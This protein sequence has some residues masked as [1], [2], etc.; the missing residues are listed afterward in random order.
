M[1]FPAEMKAV[2]NALKGCVCRDIS[3]SQILP[4]ISELRQ[5]VGDRALLRALHFLNENERV[6]QTSGGIGRG[7]FCALLAAREGFR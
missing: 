1:G 5:K 7:E 2:V 6:V 4:E 3:F